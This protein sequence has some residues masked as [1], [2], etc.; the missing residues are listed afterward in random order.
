MSILLIPFSFDFVDALSIATVLG[1]LCESVNKLGRVWSA[2]RGSRNKVAISAAPMENQSGN[3][4]AEAGKTSS[5]E[6][7][8]TLTKTPSTSNHERP[9]GIFRS[10][11]PSEDQS[12]FSGTKTSSTAQ[13]PIGLLR[14]IESASPRNN[15][16][17]PLEEKYLA[18][19]DTFSPRGK[20]TAETASAKP[21]APAAV[22]WGLALVAV[23][24]LL[25][26]VI[27]DHILN[28][29]DE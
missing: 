12:A 8:P 20:G 6:N 23:S 13:P 4:D 17:P 15:L 9:S 10:K 22:H 25:L 28:K 11:P 18:R 21:S 5:I 27:Q 1:F 16:L 26:S 14:R 29:S 24:E 3:P 7:V 19:Q 2:P